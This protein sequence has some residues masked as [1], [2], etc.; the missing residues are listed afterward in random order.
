LPVTTS[1]RRSARRSAEAGQ[2]GASVVEVSSP[3]ECR[4]HARAPQSQTCRSGQM[5][6]ETHARWDLPL[7]QI[8]SG[9]NSPIHAR[10]GAYAP[11]EKPVACQRRDRLG[12]RAKQPLLRQGPST[13]QA[14]ASEEVLM[15]TSARSPLAAQERPLQCSSR[16]R[17]GPG[18]KAFRASGPPGGRQRPSDELGTLLR[19]IWLLAPKILS[20]R[21]RVAPAGCRRN[22][23]SDQRMRTGRD[24]GRSLS[25]SAVSEARRG[26]LREGPPDPDPDLIF[27][28]SSTIPVPV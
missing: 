23:G 28:R 9:K 20:A 14:C 10:Y 1:P 7:A 11:G 2:D 24:A 3:T 13:D 21:G 5:P 18:A 25:D 16:R 12:L 6:G 4:V 19:Q 27:P 17:A 22:D 26:A 8:L 15:M